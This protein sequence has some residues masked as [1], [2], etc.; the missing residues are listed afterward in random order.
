MLRAIVTAVL[1]CVLFA[2]GGTEAPEP[3]P[4]ALD[5]DF[6]RWAFIT[7]DGQE[8]PR[9][10]GWQAEPSGAWAGQLSRAGGGLSSED[11]QVHLLIQE[12]PTVELIHQRT[13]VVRA[14][15]VFH[16]ELST[17]DD[18]QSTAGEVV[19]L[20]DWMDGACRETFGTSR[21][22]NDSAGD[23]VHTTTAEVTAAALAGCARVRLIAE[24]KGWVRVYGVKL[25]PGE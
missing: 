21:V 2:C 16:L 5:V 13:A 11:P 10:D 6:R 19:A 17:R 22:P 25:R 20:V 18:V 23:V 9:A 7:V 15:Q 12:G 8:Y 24:P 14:G 1:C 4:A 3:T